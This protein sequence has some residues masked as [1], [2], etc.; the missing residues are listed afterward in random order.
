MKHIFLNIA[1]VVVNILKLFEESEVLIDVEV[2]EIG[3]V[4]N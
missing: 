1:K 4:E 2:V 3:E